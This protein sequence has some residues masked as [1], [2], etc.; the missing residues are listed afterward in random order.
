MKLHQIIGAIPA[1]NKISSHELPLKDAYKLSKLLIAIQPDL[2]FFNHKRIDILNKYGTKAENEEN[3][4]IAPQNMDAFKAEMD[5][6]GNIETQAQITAVQLPL[7]DDIK[8]TANEISTLVPFI[9]WSDMNKCS[10]VSQK[11]QT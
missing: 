7:Y 6:L 10:T 2:D 3:Y 11:R 1:L 9:E 4:N 5:E 8:I